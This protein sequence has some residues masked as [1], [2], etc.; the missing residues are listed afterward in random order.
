MDRRYYREFENYDTVV[1]RVEDFPVLNTENKV[2]PTDAARQSTG[3]IKGLKS[4]D[5]MLLFVLV[6]LLMEDE[7]D[8]S[9]ILSVVALLL[10]EYIF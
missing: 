5:M 8:V 7:K 10:A 9:A 6:L 1:P 3:F 4:D 2:S